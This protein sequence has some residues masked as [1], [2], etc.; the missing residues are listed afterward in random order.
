MQTRRLGRTGHH[1][2]VAILGGAAFWSSTPHQA[3]AGF[4]LALDR[5]VNHLDIA[6][7]YGAAE[8]VVGPFVPAVRDRLFVA[9]KTMRESPDG[10]DAQFDD[11]RRLLGCD[12][13]DLYQAHAVTSLDLLDARGPALER[14]LDIRA[15]GGARFAGITGHGLDAPATFVEALRRYDLD[16]VMFPVYPRLWADGAY[17]A[18]AEELLTLAAE[19]D[20][21]IMAIKAVARRPWDDGRPMDDA[22]AGH[23][24]TSTRWATSWYEPQEPGDGI[25]RGVRFALS[26]PGVHVFCTPGDLTLLPMVLDAADDYA[27][28]DEGGRADAIAAMSDERPIFPMPV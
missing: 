21:G 23:P 13:L 24:D 9:G 1:S 18:A 12:A 28:L 26:T 4:Q 11:T 27:P 2:S 10:V 19:R 8:T 22:V 14:I 7:R 17:R 5:G 6:P 15:R 16:T 20:V 25:A 3:E